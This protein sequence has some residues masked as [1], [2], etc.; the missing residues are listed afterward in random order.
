YLFNLIT[1]IR[2]ALAATL[3]I[4][5]H[6]GGKYIWVGPIERVLQ[7]LTGCLLALIITYIFHVRD[8]ASKGFEVISDVQHE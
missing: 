8:C 7:V 1:P 6:E 5:L 2:S 3:V 4:L